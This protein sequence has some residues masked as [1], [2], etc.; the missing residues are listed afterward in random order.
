MDLIRLLRDTMTRDKLMFVYR[1]EVTGDNSL[2]LLMLLEREMESSEVALLGRKRLFMFVLESLQNVSRHGKGSGYADMSLVVFARTANGYAVTTGNVIPTSSAGSLRR[3]LD[4][5]N[6]LDPSEIR[7]IYRQMLSSA[8]FSTKG[9]AGL[10]LIEMAKKTGNRLDY[11][12][13]PLDA[14]HSWFI[15][16]K[17][18]DTT[19]LGNNA[20]RKPLPY[21]GKWITDLQ[22]MMARNN[23]YM[24]WS[25]H[26]TPGVGKEVLY[27][28]ETRLRETEVAAGLKKRVFA[29][30]VEVLENVALYSAGRETE[31]LFGPPVAMLM[32]ESDVYTIT[33]GNLVSISEVGALREKLDLVSTAGA[34]ALKQIMSDNLLG[35]ETLPGTKGI[36]G[37]AD[38]AL[39]SS[40]RLEYSFENVNQELSYY[41]LTVKIDGKDSH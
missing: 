10:G 12:F 2:P 3:K 31:I 35:K 13:I 29:V 8:E 5:I 20:G 9:G 25:G 23:I 37:L 1:G 36:L 40:G 17:T 34:T 7:S 14:K 11:D 30:L 33:T 15:L 19:G 21:D 27:F 39:K 4:E 38:I 6:S 24:V 32:M 26:L 16:S 41:V 22:H 28:N 18:V